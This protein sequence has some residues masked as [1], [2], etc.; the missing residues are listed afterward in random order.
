MRILAQ[1]LA[2]P[3]VD[4]AELHME[5]NRLGADDVDGGGGLGLGLGEDREKRERCQ[6]CRFVRQI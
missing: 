2:Y 4:L 6:C 5:A 3:S 1:V